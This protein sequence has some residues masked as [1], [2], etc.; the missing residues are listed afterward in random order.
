MNKTQKILACIGNIE[1]KS[2][3][4][5]VGCTYS[6]VHNVYYSN[7]DI[8]PRRNKRKIKLKPKINID[9]IIFTK[10]MDVLIEGDFKTWSVD[11]VGRGFL[12][13]I[14]NSDTRNIVKEKITKVLLP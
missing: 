2:I 4:K 12:G 11:V 6:L 9:E 14:R 3:H 10:G 13:L 8:K 1:L 7:V 5:I